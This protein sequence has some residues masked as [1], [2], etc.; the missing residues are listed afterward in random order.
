MSTVLISLLGRAMRNGRP[1]NP[2]SFPWPERLVELLK[3]RDKHVIQIGANGDTQIADT[4]LPELKFDEVTKLLQECETFISVDSYLAHH[5][6]F[7]GKPGVVI[8]SQSDPRI[9]GHDC[10]TNLLKDRKYLR[11]N[12]FEMWEQTGLND[13]AF[14]SPEEVLE[15]IK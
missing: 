4:F 9:F 12:Q 15:A 6:W 1:R 13:D 3:L 8:F 2:K 7:I 14:V 11:P 5:G 10:H